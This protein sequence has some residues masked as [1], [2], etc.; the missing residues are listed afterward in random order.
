MA[1]TSEQ[2]T[3]REKVQ[4]LV[5]GVRQDIEGYKQ[6]KVLLIR[7]RELMKCRDNNGLQRHNIEQTSL[8]DIL[9]ERAKNR[10]ITLVS[11]GFNGNSKG[12]ESLITKLPQASQ[13]QVSLLWRHL[14]TLAKESQQ[15]NEENGKLLVS[16]Q[17]VINS[18]LNKQPDSQ[19]EYAQA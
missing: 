10:S 9:M 19:Y 7:Q 15:Y 6:L 4:G 14:L 16:Q 11:L 8:I 3:T 2:Q 12:M 1:N 18:L 5:S 13:K 17:E